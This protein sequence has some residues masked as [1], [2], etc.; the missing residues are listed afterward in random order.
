MHSLVLYAT[1]KEGFVGSQP[2]CPLEGSE[3]IAVRETDTK[4]Q[5]RDEQEGVI[6]AVI[7]HLT[8]NVSTLSRRV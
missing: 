5:F 6:S 4:I 1:H 7:S 3:H 2:P 8:E